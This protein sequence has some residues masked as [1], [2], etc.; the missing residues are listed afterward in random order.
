[1]QRLC[2]RCAPWRFVQR[3]GRWGGCSAFVRRLTG[4]TLRPQSLKAPE[5]TVIALQDL[6]I[7]GKGDISRGWRDGARRVGAALAPD[8]AAFAASIFLAAAANALG[9]TT[10]S[11]AAPPCAYA[12]LYA[13]ACRAAHSCA[14]NSSWQVP[15]PATGAARVCVLDPR[16]VGAGQEVTFSYI[17]DDVARPH[18]ERLALLADAKFFRCRCA[19]CLAERASGVEWAR[20]WP[21]RRCEVGL[22]PAALGDRLHCGTA[23]EFCGSDEGE[24]GGAVTASEERRWRGEVDRRLDEAE[25]ALGQADVAAA[26]R[27][28][29]AAWD[30]AR[31]RFGLPRDV[32]WRRMGDVGR[33][34]CR[35]AGRSLDAAAFA[36]LVAAQ[37]TEGGGCAFLAAQARQ[38]AEEDRAWHEGRA[39]PLA[40]VAMLLDHLRRGGA[41]PGVQHE[42]GSAL[43]PCLGDL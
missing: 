16:G 20:C 12:G 40:E 4:S 42:V 18:A 15:D 1:M 35:A 43:A 7:P 21:C 11:Q 36:G 26:A 25:A 5:E 17:G 34:V 13:Q 19:R 8:R 2:G 28:V 37:A 31:P 29:R 6:H 39:Q 14:A 24:V 41:L 22:R 38:W 30:A 32:V 3:A 9:G 23:C 33:D 10:L 27:H